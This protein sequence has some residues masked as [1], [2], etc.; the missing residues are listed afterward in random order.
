MIQDFIVIE[1]A[2]DSTTYRSTLVSFLSPGSHIIPFTINEP[3]SIL[4]L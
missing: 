3:G 1:T 2:P 4:R